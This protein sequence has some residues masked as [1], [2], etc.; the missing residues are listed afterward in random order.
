MRLT[1]GFD[2]F[3]RRDLDCTVGGIE[4]GYKSD[5]GGK[6]QSQGYQPRRDNGYISAVI[7]RHIRAA[8]G[9]AE[10][11]H[12]EGDHIAEDNADDA[13][14]KADGAGFHQEDGAD[15]AYE[16]AQHLHTTTPLHL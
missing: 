10:G 15:I 11:I 6:D 14:H 2:G 12:G 5:A 1:V 4:P 13:A 16:A 3:Q 9:E 7:G 8:H